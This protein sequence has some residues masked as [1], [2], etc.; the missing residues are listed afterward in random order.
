MEPEEY[1]IWL[2]LKVGENFKKTV[3][4]TRLRSRGFA[5]SLSDIELITIEL[6]AEYQ[7]HGNDKSIWRYMKQHWSS[8]FPALGSYKNFNQA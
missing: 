8:W 6:F 2:Y 5:P 1:L 3:G 7:G 4:D